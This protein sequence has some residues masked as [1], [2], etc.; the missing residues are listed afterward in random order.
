ME[1]QFTIEEIKA[2]YFNE[3]A[4]TEPAY[5]IYRLDTDGWRY[6]YRFE[7]DTPIFYPSVTTMLKSVM[8]TPYGLL[9]WYAQNG[10]ESATE[11]RDLAAAYGTFMHS[12]FERLIIN[13]RYDFD[14]VP[15]VLMEYIQRENLPDKVFGEWEK[16]IRKD[17]LAF[18]QFVKD[19]NVRPLAVEIG[20]VSARYHYAGCID[21]PCIM[22]DK[23][24]NDYTAIVDFKSGR[25]GFYED[26]ELQLELYRMMWEENF[27]TPIEKIYNFAPNDW[28]KS[29]TYT[30]KDQTGSE[31]LKKIPYLLELAKIEDE[32][33]DNVVTLV[34]G[35]INLDDEVGF[36]DNVLNLSLA[37]VIKKGLAKEKTPEP[38]ENAM[39]GLFKESIE[40][41]N[42]LTKDIVKDE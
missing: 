12:Q 28:R 23:K 27:G 15:N 42:N 24:G 40:A 16:K 8:P 41:F 22:T 26:C 30:L 25:K 6:Y 9:Q 18:A 36:E 20:L 39:G 1:E 13:R 14:N 3:E 2:L 11:K 38:D 33:R 29:P 5:K 10:M 17:V 32:K 37:D 35:S 21:L 34:R 19:Y 31:N 4:L 7:K